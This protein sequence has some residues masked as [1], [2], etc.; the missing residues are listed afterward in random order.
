VEG[1]TCRMCGGDGRVGN[2]LGGSSA[3]CPSC[4]GS[5]RRAEASSGF[6][7]VTKTKPSH[8]RPAVTVSPGPRVPATSE[9]MQLAQEV[10][11]STVLAA[12]AKTRLIAEIVN[13]ESTHGRCTKTFIKK[14]RKQARP[15]G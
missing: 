11:A 10:N 13:H 5:G 14:V 1:E 7:D 2:A 9:G 3:T 8:H 12:D 6:H 15:A 4:H